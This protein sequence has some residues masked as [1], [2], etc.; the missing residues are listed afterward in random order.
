MRPSSAHPDS[1]RLITRLEER[2]AAKTMSAFPRFAWRWIVSTTAA[3]TLLMAAL[4]SVGQAAT[5]SAFGGTG[6]ELTICVSSSGLIRGVNVE[7]NSGQT[8]VGPFET[9]GPQGEQGPQGV[10]GPPGSQGPRA[11]RVSRV[12]RERRGRLGLRVTR[13]QPVLRA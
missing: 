10:Q 7:C 3:T 12:C 4:P 9:V 2:H 5:P 8:Q 11:A 13:A 6:A 1:L